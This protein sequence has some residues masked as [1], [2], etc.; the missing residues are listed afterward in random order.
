L[1]DADN[2]AFG[3]NCQ[4]V[5]DPALMGSGRPEHVPQRAYV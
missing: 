3:P 1:T 2:S 5:Y 4:E